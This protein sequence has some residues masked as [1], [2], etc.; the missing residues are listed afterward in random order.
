M[1]LAEIM[2]LVAIVSSVLTPFALMSYRQGKIDTKVDTL[3]S[4]YTSSVLAREAL[5]HNPHPCFSLPLPD[6]V[7]EKVEKTKMRT[8]IGIVGFTL[9]K[10]IGVE[11]IRQIALQN[12]VGFGEVVANMVFAWQTK[13]DK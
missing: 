6:D 13:W 8:D 12:K 11:R 2:S 9:V 1:S 5:R 10:K 3:W 7:K 4:V